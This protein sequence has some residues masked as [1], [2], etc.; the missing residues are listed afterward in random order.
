[1]KFLK[2]GAAVAAIGLVVAVGGAYVAPIWF[3][4]RQNV[5]AN[6]ADPALIEQGRSVAEASDCVACHTAKGGKPFAGGLAM[7][8]PIG[9]IYSTNITPDKDTGIGGYDFADFERA[10]RHGV[11]KDGSPLY[12]AMPYISYSVLT[13]G[14]VQALYSFFAS[15][16]Q[17]VSQPNQPS[18]IPWPQNMRWP[19]AWWQMLF[20]GHSR[21]APPEGA[22][23]EVVR[24]AYL[25]EGAG[26]CGACH[27]PRGAAFQEVA[28]K[29]GPD[30]AFLS[31][32]ALEGWYAKSLRHEDVGL[33]NWSQQE[34]ADFLK[35]G[36]NAR[37][38]A[39]GSMA[40]VVQ[41]SAQHFS[42]TDASAIAAFLVSRAP[43]PGHA[44]AAPKAEDTTTA[45]LY[46][47]ADRSPGALGYVAQCAPCHR[48]N[49]QGTPRLFPALAGNS[50]V[51]TQDPSSLIQITL[52]GGAMAKTPADKTHPSMPELSRLDDIA[53][54]D[55]LTF[56]RNSWGNTATPVSAADV[57]AM[58]GVIAG[59]PLDYIPER[60]SPTLAASV[61]AGQELAL[62]RA[63]GNCLACHTL[64]GGDAPSNV[65]RELVDMKRRFPIRGDL[66]EILTDESMRNPIAP[67]PSLGR[68]H[69]L[70]R[71]EIEQIIDFL[72]TL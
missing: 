32:S 58:R 44:A 9:V 38:A 51:T 45:K 11:R 72:Y 15:A 50:A 4:P 66:V 69:V 30:G 70:S 59:K 35:T 55:I 60:P 31:G 62:D 21:F 57:A 8:T 42:E 17:P 49:G 40:D 1:M 48:L 52:A 61:K 20:G 46:D 22:T 43:R 24:G 36:R 16:V 41:H 19:L 54:A 14:D 34:I 29:D 39:F 6:A 47:S 23:P 13:D 5:H 64:K 3:A 63:K 28:L 33:G 65:G 26:H 53:V 2:L 25:V 67:M 7:Q 18:T 56:V 10:V 12:P 71:T 68:N 37:T 27:T